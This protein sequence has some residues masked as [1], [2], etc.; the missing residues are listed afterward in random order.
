[1]YQEQQHLSARC[2]SHG[3]RA[4]SPHPSGTQAEASL[5]DLGHK[6]AILSD[7]DYDSHP[8]IE[9]SP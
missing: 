1:M 6:I 2:S 5:L 8:G 4:A 9:L 3:T 7:S